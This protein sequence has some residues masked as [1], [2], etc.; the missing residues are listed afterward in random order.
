MPIRK[1]RDPFNFSRCRFC[2]HY[3][4]A[5]SSKLGTNKHC[6]WKDF[7]LIERCKC[8]GFA[9]VE[10]LEFLEWEYGKLDKKFSN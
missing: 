1:I 6:E 3:F 8:K 5:H 2:N 7:D 10:N 4:L 9:P